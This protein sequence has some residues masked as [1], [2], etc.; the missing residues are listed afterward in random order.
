[1]SYRPLTSD[2]AEK[3]AHQILK[4]IEITSYE[5]YARELYGDKAYAVTVDIDGEYDDQGSTDYYVTSVEVVDRESN[6]LEPDYNLPFWGE[7]QR[8]GYELPPANVPIWQYAFDGEDDALDALLRG[9][10]H[11][12]PVEAGTF[13]FSELAPFPIPT[14]FVE[15]S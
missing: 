14:L 4:N 9:R 10:E 13:F 7:W 11:G 2:E 15:E 6:D 3:Y 5:R 1:M 8:R 12:I